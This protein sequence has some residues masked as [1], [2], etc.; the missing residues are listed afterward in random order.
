MRRA[1]R[2]HAAAFAAIVG[3]IAVALPVALYIVQQQRLR[4]PF[5]DPDPVRIEV[6]LPEANAV[7]PGQGQTAQVAG[8]TIGSIA[9][10][11]LEDGR[12]VVG[13]DIEPEYDDLI[14]T[15]A[16]ALLR[17]R[18]GLKDMY[19][20]IFP[21]SAEA[22]LIEE[23]GRIAIAN[24]A[25]D[26]DLDEILGTF[27]ERTR[28]YLR[29]L[30][31]GTGE[32][33]R[34]N[35]ERLAEVFERFAPT[36]RDLARVNRA[37]AAEQGELRRVVRNL[38]LLNERLADRP[39]DLAELVDTASSTFGAFASEEDDL[40]ATVSEL[41]PTLERATTTLRDVGPLARELGPATRALVPAV[42]ALDESNEEVRPFA[43]EA[44]PIVAERIRPF[45][46]EARP[47]ARDLAP[48]A[49]ALA[50]TF[51]EVRRG[52]RT[53]NRFLNLLAFN[54]GGAEGPDVAGREEGFLFWTAWVAHQ[55]LNLQSVEDA[56]GPL[57]PVLLGGTCATLGLLT[58][59]EPAL[60][61]ALNLSPALATQCGNPG[62]PSVTPA[63]AGAL[64]PRIRPYLPPTP[65]A[66]AP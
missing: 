42:R 56:N 59:G 49:E 34:D 53:L 36:M 2:D 63:V 15:D 44:A 21:G 23:G 13:L 18:T 43:R 24:T 66:T 60:E 3:L 55:G 22:P 62:S 48:A 9:D 5:L 39:D 32:G 45:V 11:R 20:Q 6:V 26:V 14:H 64:R 29:L 12:A 61:F 4:I 46:R 52:G 41:A 58:T 17:P 65:P 1:I 37:V 19:V 33:L 31:A 50:E 16:R 10:V 38:G 35:G 30:V 40:R 27:D 54:P 8:V 28:D 57:R 47:L 51:P 25:T 7:T